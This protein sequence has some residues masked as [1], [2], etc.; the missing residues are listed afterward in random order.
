M[1]RSNIC[2][3]FIFSGFLF[4][5]TAAIPT[6]YC[7][8][9]SI[10]VDNSSIPN[11]KSLSW[12]R[13]ID[14]NL[15][16]RFDNDHGFVE[17]EHGLMRISIHF[18]GKRNGKLRA[19]TSFVNNNHAESIERPIVLT[20]YKKSVKMTEELLFDVKHG[21]RSRIFILQYLKLELNGRYYLIFL[22][23][24]FN[25][26]FTCQ[27]HFELD[28]IILKV[29]NYTQIKNGRISNTSD[30]IPKMETNDNEM[31]QKEPT[32]ESLIRLKFLLSFENNFVEE[33]TGETQTVL[34]DQINQLDSN[35]RID[36]MDMTESTTVLMS[37][38]ITAVPYE[39]EMMW[40]IISL[41]FIALTTILF[42]AS[43]CLWR[44]MPP[45][46]PKQPAKATRV[47]FQVPRV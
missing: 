46:A 13:G 34:I 37:T 3:N 39:H 26:S 7:E 2:L 12:N 36:P 10:S 22:Y 1:A 44:A 47:S 14:E 15:H 31:E 33:G 29:E 35:E 42:I 23:L 6:D 32:A 18:I 17:N 19:T 25:M 41:I 16:F 4:I 27:K 11:D 9:M 43:I 28:T 38:E 24:Q 30:P 21:V 8:I 45:A 5:L 20:K 40:K